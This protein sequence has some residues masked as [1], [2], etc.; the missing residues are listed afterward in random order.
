MNKNLSFWYETIGKKLSEGPAEG[1]TH[2]PLPTRVKK[3][4]AANRLGAGIDAYFIADEHESYLI[5]KTEMADQ[6]GLRFLASEKESGAR[7]IGRWLVEKAPLDRTWMVGV[8]GKANINASLQIS[9]PPLLCYFCEANKVMSFNLKAVREARDLMGEIPWKEIMAP[10]LHTYSQYIS[11]GNETLR[12]NL[13]EKLNKMLKKTPALR[14]LL[15]KLNLRP[16]SG[17]YEVLS[18]YYRTPFDIAE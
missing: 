2:P 17:E 10:A 12:K 15:P 9:Q 4:V 8:I 14:H 13:S 3:G 1:S 16:D 7:F 18:W 6:P 11:A 5:S